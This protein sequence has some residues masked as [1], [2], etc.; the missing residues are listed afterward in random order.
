[1]KIVAKW[2]DLSYV[3][4]VDGVETLRTKGD[5]TAARQMFDAELRK[6]GVECYIDPWTVKTLGGHGGYLVF[7]R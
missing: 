7:K 3:I 4:K 5:G 2:E 1:M 6:L